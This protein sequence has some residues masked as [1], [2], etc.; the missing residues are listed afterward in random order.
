MCLW[1]DPTRVG[2]K[3]THKQIVLLLQRALVLVGSA[4]HSI[5]VE[6]RKTAWARIYPTLKSLADEEYDRQEGKLFGP[7]FLLK[8]KRL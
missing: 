1:A 8:Q 6:R 3:P 2:D 4:S 5:S 7:G